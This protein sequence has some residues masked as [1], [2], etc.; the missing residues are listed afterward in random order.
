MNVAE[1]LGLPDLDGDLDRVDVALREAVATEDAFLAE[2]GVHLIRAGGKR[3]R[4]ALTLAAGVACGSLATDELVL[5]GVACELMHLGSLYHDDV[6]DDADTRRGVASVNAKYGNLVAILAGDFLLG[7]ASEIATGLGNEV[8]GVLAR[9]LVRMCEGQLAELQTGF[10]TARTEERYLVSIGGK[11]AALMAA[12]CRIGGLT[13][14][15]DRPTIEGLTAFGE[16][17]GTAFQIYDDIA[18]LVRTDEDLGKPAGHDMVEGVYTLPVIYAL[19]E[20]EAGARLAALLGGALEP[21]ARDEA[22]AVVR[23]SG[24]V[25]RAL[26]SGRA[27]AEDAA[28]ALAPLPAGPVKEA[29]STLGH[30]LLDTLG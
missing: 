3:F 27:R 16:A 2:V 9:T 15:A 20:P 5:G 18:D 7:R 1:L 26:A 11:T 21:D 19:A 24:G 29:L 22:I 6:M 25:T 10:S 8:S 28:A 13:S 30:R 12:A 23:S 14:G 4:P 17:F